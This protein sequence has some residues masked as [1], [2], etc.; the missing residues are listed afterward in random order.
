MKV[1]PAL[2]QLGFGVAFGVALTRSGAADF[3]AMERMFLF[4]EA[5][6]FLLG[7]ATTLVAIVGLRFA[8][9]SRWSAGVRSAPRPL[10]R[11]SVPGGILF[12]LGWG[13][14]GTCPGTAIAQFGSGHLIAG[15]TLGGILLGNWLFERFVSGKFGLTRESCE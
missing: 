15:F 6:L 4:E 8:L 3:D 12:G 13:L 11:G 10:H 7:A 5:H 1:V 2:V 14:S 9:R